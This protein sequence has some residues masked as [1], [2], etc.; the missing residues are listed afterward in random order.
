MERLVKE[1]CIS[2][3]DFWCCNEPGDDVRPYCQA[4]G[5]CDWF[6][7]EIDAAEKMERINFLKGDEN[8]V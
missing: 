4:N 6:D 8:G 1:R 2:C 7:G 3:A 5:F